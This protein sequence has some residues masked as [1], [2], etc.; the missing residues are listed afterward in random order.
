MPFPDWLP[1]TSSFRVDGPPGLAQHGLV[2]R[3]GSND[4]RPIRDIQ[5]LRLISQSRAL[6]KTATCGVLRRERRR[7]ANELIEVFIPAPPKVWRN[8][9][10]ARRPRYWISHRE[11]GWSVGRS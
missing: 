8:G 3:N 4:D 9:V 6:G 5:C 10:S 11:I 2:L 1:P 7:E